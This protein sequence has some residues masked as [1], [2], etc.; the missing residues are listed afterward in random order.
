[1]T[2]TFIPP[3]AVEVAYVQPSG[4]TAPAVICAD[5]RGRGQVD[6]HVRGPN[7]TQRPRFGVPQIGRR[8]VD[9]HDD[10]G[11][12]FAPVPVEA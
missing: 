5:L 4:A 1:M 9:V 6:L 3:E 12:C 11:C 10:A 7:D 2:D 8:A